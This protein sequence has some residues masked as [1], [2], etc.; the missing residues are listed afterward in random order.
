MQRGGYAGQGI[1]LAHLGACLY[2]HEMRPRLTRLGVPDR[3]APGGSLA[4]IRKTLGLAALDL[5]IYQLNY[6]G[7]KISRVGNDRLLSASGVGTGSLAQS[8]GRALGFLELVS[9]KVTLLE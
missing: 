6:V 4:Y 8:C 3:W 7:P 9:Q 5:M 2:F 1:A